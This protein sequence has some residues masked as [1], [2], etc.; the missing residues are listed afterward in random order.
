MPCV[1]HVGVTARHACG[2]CGQ[3]FPTSS[4]VRRHIAHSAQCRAVARHSASAA[5]QWRFS[6]PE[7]NDLLAFEDGAPAPA[8]APEEE[9]VPA[10]DD[11]HPQGLDGGIPEDGH[12]NEE[13]EQFPRYAMEF[14]EHA[15]AEVLGEAKT[16]FQVMKDIQDASGQGMYAPFA[17]RE[18]WELAEWLISNANQ[19]AMDKF[20]KLSIVSRQE[21]RNEVYSPLLGARLRI[22]HDRVIK[23]STPL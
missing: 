13:P 14:N 19:G 1:G 3:G 6:S 2:H 4:S 15:A 16:S 17:D 5:P 11:E 7:C 18:E 21:S 9:A 20:L 23:A 10:L 8:S 12:D 22:G